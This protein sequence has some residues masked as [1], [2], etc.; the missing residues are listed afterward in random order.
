MFH[1]KHRQRIAGF[2]VMVFLSVLLIADGASART[3]AAQTEISSPRVQ[4]KA[5]SNPNLGK[6]KKFPILF[7]ALGAAAAVGLILFLGKKKA[8]PKPP[9]PGP[10]TATYVGGIL[11]VKGV[12]YELMSIPAGAFQMGSVSTEAFAEEKPVHAVRISNGFWLGRTEVTQG[13]WQAVMGN[14]PAHFK[15]GDD[16]PLEMVSWDDCQQFIA[17]LNQMTGGNRFRLPTEA[18]WEYACRAGTEGERY[19]NLDAVAW[20]SGNSGDTTHPVAQ[21]QSNA[22][23]LYDMLGNIYEWCSDWYAADYYTQSPAADPL[24]PAAGTMKISRGGCS[25]F[26]AA[27][28]RAAHRQ[29]AETLHKNYG[30]GLRLA[31]ISA[32]S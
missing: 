28:T 4:E 32:G 19:G 24:G 23:G 21:K 29:T 20:Y 26:D 11:T 5:G 18:E 31:A 9:A 22:W 13:L 17:K 8:D 15:S 12:R 16:Y 30:M 2:T 7:V 10:E 25:F 3:N 27:H 14:N 6:K 1:G